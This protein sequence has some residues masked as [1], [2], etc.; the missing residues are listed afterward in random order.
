[1]TSLPLSS[2]VGSTLYEIK[3]AREVRALGFCWLQSFLSRHSSRDRWRDLRARWRRFG[4]CNSDAKSPPQPCNP[5]PE[6]QPAGSRQPSGRQP[7]QQSPKHSGIGSDADCCALHFSF[8]VNGRCHLK[9]DVNALPRPNFPISN[10]ALYYRQ[11]RLIGNSWRR[12]QR[13]KEDQP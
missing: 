8:C 13:V 9:Q 10:C 5:R 6:L 4:R 3:P 11:N 1:M 2:A 7:L 12:A